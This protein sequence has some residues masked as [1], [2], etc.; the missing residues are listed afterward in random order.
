MYEPCECERCKPTWDGYVKRFIGWLDGKV[1]KKFL[2]FN[3]CPENCIAMIE[4]QELL[5]NDGV[6]EVDE[7]E[8]D[9]NDI[10]GEAIEAR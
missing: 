6:E 9:L 2:V 1:L 3:Y 10:L 7:K 5:D 8:G 4:I